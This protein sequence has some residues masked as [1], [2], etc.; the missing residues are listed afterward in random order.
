M[1]RPFNH[2]IARWLCAALL[3][4]ATGCASPPKPLPPAPLPA[5]A[6][7]PKTESLCSP[8]CSDWWSLQA[9][10]WRALLTSAATQAPPVS[11]SPK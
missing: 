11:A 1:Q 7:Q 8:T 10:K 6:K 4:L 3:P 5:I 2:R 9:E